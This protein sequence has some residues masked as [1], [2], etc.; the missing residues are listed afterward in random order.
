M[1][2]GDKCAGMRVIP[3][4][5]DRALM[6]KVLL[7]SPDSPVFSVLPYRKL[8]YGVITTGSEVYTGRNVT[9]SQGRF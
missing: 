6:D 5:V 8:S 9:I 3:L 7:D 2:K 1:H 4:M